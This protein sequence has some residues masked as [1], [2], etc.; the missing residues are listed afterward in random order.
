MAATRKRKRKLVRRASTRQGATAV[1]EKFPSIP[2]DEPVESIDTE[3]L[4]EEDDTFSTV[5]DDEIPPVEDRA[6]P[7]DEE[8]EE[9]E[10]GA[11]GLRQDMALCERAG[12]MATCV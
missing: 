11:E 8:E 5:V 12:R 3:P 4:D 10:R 6:C 9:D 7:V 2:L 1:D